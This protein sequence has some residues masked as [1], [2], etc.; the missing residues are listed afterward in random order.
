MNRTLLGDWCDNLR[1][2]DSRFNFFLR[3][4]LIWSD[5]SANRTVDCHRQGLQGKSLI[6][7][8]YSTLCGLEERE[9]PFK[10][11]ESQ[12]WKRRLL[13]KEEDPGNEDDINQTGAWAWINGRSDLDVGCCDLYGC[14][15]VSH[16]IML[17]CISVVFTSDFL[18]YSFSTSW[19]SAMGI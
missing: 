14:D 8:V 13:D 16:F 1:L 11:Q 5:I 2:L 4:N 6:I 9:G 18:N 19:P 7:H 15:D 3:S 12:P 10:S 17:K